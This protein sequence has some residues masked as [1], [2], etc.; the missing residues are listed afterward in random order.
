MERE[1]KHHPYTS[2]WKRKHTKSSGKGSTRNHPYTSKHKC[3]LRAQHICER[4]ASSH[5]SVDNLY[6]K[7]L[8]SSKTNKPPP[9]TE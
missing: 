6:P 1:A 4:R 9:V 3:S 2:R 5:T 8:C 7:P